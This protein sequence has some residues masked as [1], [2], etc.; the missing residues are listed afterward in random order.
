MKPAETII[1]TIQL[2]EKALRLSE[3]ENKYLFRV[4]RRA[5]KMEIKQAVEELFGVD[6]T[7]V[8]TMNRQGKLKRAGGRKE[9]RRSA[10][11]RAVVT[12]KDGDTIDFT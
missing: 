1:D 7:G 3:A 9:G 2:T 8:N 12:L 10:W 6:V 5:N 11:K 4:D